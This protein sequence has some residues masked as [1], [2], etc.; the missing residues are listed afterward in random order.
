MREAREGGEAMEAG[1]SWH[2]AAAG[3]GRAGSGGRDSLG[4]CLATGSHP[5]FHR[6]PRASGS[7]GGVVASTCQACR[8]GRG[9]GQCRVCRNGKN[10]QKALSLGELPIAVSLDSAFRQGHC[11]PGI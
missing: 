6:P 11:L 3:S 2:P 10:Q 7:R 5:T 4:S 8:V 9:K 1:E